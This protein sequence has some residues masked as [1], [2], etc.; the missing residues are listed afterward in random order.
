MRN[1]EL[2]KLGL[3]ELRA[4]ELTS[5]EGGSFWSWLGSAIAYIGFAFALGSG[6]ISSGNF[7]FGFAL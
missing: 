5:I 4:A 1:L 3:V 6:T 2:E 7:S